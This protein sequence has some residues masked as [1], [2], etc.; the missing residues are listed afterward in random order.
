MNI[1]NTAFFVGHYTV[2][3]QG[4]RFG[5]ISLR[6]HAPQ[7]P[8]SIMMSVGVVN[9]VQSVSPLTSLWSA[10]TACAISNCFVGNGNC[11]RQNPV[12]SVQNPIFKLIF[13]PFCTELYYPRATYC[14]T[15]GKVSIRR[16]RKVGVALPKNEQKS[17]LA[18]KITYQKQGYKLYYRTRK[19]Y[20]V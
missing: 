6:A 19:V 8:R 14:R 3:M 13:L 17:K 11:T 7:C 5:L 9:Q 4:Y 2:C 12:Q 15:D 20:S 18:V 10:L 1:T 16:A